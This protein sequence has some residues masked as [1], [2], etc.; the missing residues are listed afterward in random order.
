MALCSVHV[1]GYSISLSLRPLENTTLW[2]KFFRKPIYAARATYQIL[3]ISHTMPQ[4]Q[5]LVDVARW[6]PVNYW[7]IDCLWIIVKCAS[8]HKV[9]VERNLETAYTKSKPCSKICFPPCTV[10]KRVARAV[11]AAS[12]HNARSYSPFSLSDSR[13]LVPS[14][15]M[16]YV[17][18]S[19][20]RR[21]HFEK[22]KKITRPTWA[23]AS[24]AWSGETASPASS[25]RAARE[26]GAAAPD[27]SR[28]RPNS[29]GPRPW[30]RDWDRG[31][32]RA[33]RHSLWGKLDM[34]SP[35]TALFRLVADSASFPR[36]PISHIP[37]APGSALEHCTYDYFRV[38]LNGPRNRSRRCSPT[39]TSTALARDR[40]NKRPPRPP[41]SSSRATGASA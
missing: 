12:N 5:K 21:P 23:S 20:R 39:P 2:G 34:P 24:R 7:A 16:K 17:Y 18:R 6:L 31:E 29:R 9:H 26:R 35:T 40:S 14:P 27:P 32:Q 28:E 11:V 25:R 8:H 13:S 1:P 15:G 10:H 33:M 37:V 41:D 19:V 38:S 4:T 36:H 22:A 30:P 3:G